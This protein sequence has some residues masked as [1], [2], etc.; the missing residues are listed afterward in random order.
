MPRPPFRHIWTRIVT[1]RGKLFG[2]K[3]AQLTLALSRVHPLVYLLIYLTAIPTFGLLY[4]FVTPGAFYAPYARYEPGAISDT[5]QLASSLEAALHRSFDARSGQEFVVGSWKLDLGSVRVDDIRSAD[6]TQLSFRVRLSANGIDELSGVASWAGR[7]LR[8]SRS[9]P[10]APPFTALTTL[11]HTEFQT[12]ISPSM[13]RHLRRKTQTSSG[14]FS[15]RGCSASA[16]WPLR[17]R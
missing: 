4:V 3:A 5:V 9:D 7:L 10:L 16:S 17:W 15:V 14:S 2:A 12:L 11:L 1:R 6:G 8:R 13:V